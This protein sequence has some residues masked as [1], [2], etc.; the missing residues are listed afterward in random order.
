MLLYVHVV[1]K[2]LACKLSAEIVSDSPAETYSWIMADLSSSSSESPSTQQLWQSLLEW[3]QTKHG[4]K[5]DADPLLV[6]SRDVPGKKRTF[7]CQ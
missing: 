3:L 1:C 6:E 2:Y 5:V 4:M 7:A